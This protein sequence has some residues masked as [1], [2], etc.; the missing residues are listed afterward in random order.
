MKELKDY[1]RFMT[2]RQVGEFLG[3]SPY[4]LSDWRI[5]GRGPRFHKFEGNVRYSRTDVDN[6]LA[7]T[8]KGGNSEG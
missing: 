8:V 3:I 7:E 1:P 4:T 6:Y 5:Q 2:T